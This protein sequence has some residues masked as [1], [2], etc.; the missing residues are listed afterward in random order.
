[1]TG[2]KT[3]GAIFSNNGFPKEFTNSVRFEP[4][5]VQNRKV[6]KKEV[7]CELALQDWKWMYLEIVRATAPSA[8][9]Y[10]TGLADLTATV[11]TIYSTPTIRSISDGLGA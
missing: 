2:Q 7:I 3:R 10:N 11:R 8:V 4:N 9:C 1:M 6:S 5:F